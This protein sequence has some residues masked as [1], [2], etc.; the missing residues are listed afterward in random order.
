MVTT[1]TTTTTIVQAGVSLGGSSDV[2]S[3]PSKYE[4]AAAKAAPLMDGRVLAAFDKLGFKI[5]V[6]STVSYAGFFDAKTRSLILRKEDETV[7][8]ELGHFLAFIAGNADKAA[9]FNSVYTQE[10]G[11][12]TGINK[13][14]ATQN[15]SEYF[16][17]S[18]KDY[19][20]NPAA[21]RASRPLTC[22]A[23]E[24]TLNKVTDAQIDKVQ[25]IYGPI[26]K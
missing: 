5:S 9:A 3:K 8:H 2:V 25:K 24:D 14:Y 10:K 6:D 26:W 23:I 19:M 17:E 1:V 16:A 12:Y 18:V 20:L 7:Y 11:S 13:A 15:S 4:T 21:L 22:K